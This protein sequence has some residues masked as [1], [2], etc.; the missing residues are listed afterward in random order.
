VIDL[1]SELVFLIRGAREG[2]IVL[3]WRLIH[4]LV[5]YV[6]VVQLKAEYQY[7]F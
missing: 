3:F 5:Y 7:L 2:L 1:Q 4:F 6:S